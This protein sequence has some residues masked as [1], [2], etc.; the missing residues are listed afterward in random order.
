LHFLGNPLLPL[1]VPEQGW[2]EGTDQH[3]RTRTQ[4]F[5]KWAEAWY[6]KKETQA[7]AQADAQADAQ[8]PAAAAIDKKSQ[9]CCVVS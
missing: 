1:F 4:S 2:F 5:D 3:L 7:N 6:E 9:K 8:E